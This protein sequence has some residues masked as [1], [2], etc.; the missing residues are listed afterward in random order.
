MVY[1][2]IINCLRLNFMFLDWDSTKKKYTSHPITVFL[3]YRLIIPITH[4]ISLCTD[5]CIVWCFKIV[6]Y[7]AMAESEL[8]QSQAMRMA[9]FAG[10]IPPTTE[11]YFPHEPHIFCHVSA[12]I[13]HGKGD[14]GVYV[15]IDNSTKTIK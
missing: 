12:F 8:F 2:N 10:R 9:R 4:N 14:T 15:K 11:I 5:V 3:S 6:Y 13:D 1:Y 7:V